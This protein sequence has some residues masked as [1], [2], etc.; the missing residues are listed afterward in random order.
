MT[1][2]GTGRWWRRE[3][4]DN[5]I[6]FILGRTKVDF[7]PNKDDINRKKHKYSLDCAVDVI[8]NILTFHKGA[9]Y[10]EYEKN[11]ERR[12]D[13][14]AEYE[15]NIVHVTATM[16][17][18]HVVRAISMRLASHEERDFFGKNPPQFDISALL[19]E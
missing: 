5:E 12:F 10:R 18:R 15:G 3:M 14:L 19:G 6:C 2:Q 7:D 17:K 8:T 16:R 11:N 13:M 1:W 9:L 4:S